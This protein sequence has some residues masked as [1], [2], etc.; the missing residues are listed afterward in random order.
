VK[1][2]NVTSLHFTHYELRI[3]LF[4]KYPIYLATLLILCLLTY[5]LHFSE[6]KS[7]PSVELPK[8]IVHQK[9]N[10]KMLLIP[11]GEFL[12]GSTE[13][14][15]DRYEAEAEESN[16]RRWFTDE[17]PQHTVYLDAYYIDR[18][19]VTNAQYRKFVEEA[20][21]REPRYWDSGGRRHRFELP[22][23]PVIGVSW[24]DAVAYAEWAGKRLPTEAEWEKAAR[25]TDGRRYPWGDVFDSDQC[26]AHLRRS[27]GT[28]PVGSYPSG[29]S[30][31]GLLD[32]AGN[33]WEWCADWYGSDYYTKSPYKNPQGPQTGDERVLRGGAWW[34]RMPAAETRCTYRGGNAPTECHS[35]FGFRLVKDV[36]DIQH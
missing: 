6:S 11:A 17:A 22:D 35:N 27:L 15:I 5:G 4:M 24:D 13:A 7:V 9:D 20:V 10:S 29:A 26:N 34:V 23:Q 31:Y 33:V 28:Q 32:M 19:E 30:P 2:E 8:A 21:Y 25:G 18:Y 36:G 12:M 3:M 16:A 14:E 1:R